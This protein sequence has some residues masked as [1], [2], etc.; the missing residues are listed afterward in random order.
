MLDEV[1]IGVEIDG[2]TAAW[3]ADDAIL[4][5]LGIG[6]GLSSI[7]ELRFV[8]ENSAGVGQEVVPGF[9]LVAAGGFP[10]HVLPLVPL[11][12]VLHASQRMEMHSVMPTVGRARI[13]HV[14]RMIE[15]AGDDAFVTVETK[16]THEPDKRL[17]STITGTAFIRGAA[18]QGVPRQRIPSA[19]TPDRPADWVVVAPI[20]VNQALI[21]RLS[22]DRNPLHSDP[23]AA[24]D[25]GFP[26][27]IVHGLCSFG[28]AARTLLATV[29]RGDTARFGVIESRFAS[30]LMPG[31]SLSFSIWATEDGAVFEAHAGER[32]VLGRGVFTLR[33]CTGDSRADT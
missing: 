9:A 13:T 27:P 4:Y 6:A 30:V 8:T 7:D 25:A 3:S 2:G 33:G 16:L 32:L 24:R 26:S 10:L 15:D 22:G 14:V 5:A 23:A 1:G 18:G 12:R 17:I 29:V 20:A 31:E 19:G 11:N 28:F 21:Y